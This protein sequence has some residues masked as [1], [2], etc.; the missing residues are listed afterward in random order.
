MKSCRRIKWSGLKKSSREIEN[1]NWLSK[2][3]LKLRE[4]D[5]ISKLCQM[6]LSMTKATLNK[7]EKEKNNK[8]RERLYKW[9]RKKISKLMKSFKRSRKNKEKKNKEKS[10]KWTDNPDKRAPEN[11]RKELR[12]HHQAKVKLNM[13]NKDL[14]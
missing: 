5:K 12:Q 4:Q 13:R 1:L 10:L 9:Q 2:E 6:K 14:Y 7:W 11:A 3:L 8:K